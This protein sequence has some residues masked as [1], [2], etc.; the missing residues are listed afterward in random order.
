MVESSNGRCR[1]VSRCSSSGS[2]SRTPCTRSARSPRVPGRPFAR[3]GSVAEHA[4]ARRRRARRTRSTPY[5]YAVRPNPTAAIEEKFGSAPVRP[6]VGD[7]TVWRVR[8]FP[9]VA[10][11]PSLEIRRGT[12][13]GGRRRACAAPCGPGP[14]RL[15]RPGARDAAPPS[16]PARHR[17][18]ASARQARTPAARRRAV[19]APLGC[20]SRSRNMDDPPVFHHA[21]AAPECDGAEKRRGAARSNR[22][23]P[24]R[25]RGCGTSFTSP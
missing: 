16:P 14:R 7:E 19:R 13:R 18:K 4:V 1:S 11:R 25:A 6:A 20:H 24:C 3:S 17:T 15:P 22:Q 10:E 9:E 21:P 8:E 23:D 5:G 12:G 2:G